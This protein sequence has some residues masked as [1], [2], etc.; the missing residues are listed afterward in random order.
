MDLVRKHRSG[1]AVRNNKSGASGGEV[2]KPL[3]PVSL[4]PWVHRAGRLVEDQDWRVPYKCSRKRQPLPFADAQLDALIEP[5]A[6]EIFVAVGK[7]ANQGIGARGFSGG[8]D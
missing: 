6:E 1:K 4:G 2:A 5:V 3:Q 7:P 8:L